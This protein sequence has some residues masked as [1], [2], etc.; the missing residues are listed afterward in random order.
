MNQTNT[1]QG[2]H[3][4]VAWPPL[5][6]ILIGGVLGLFLRYHEVS[7]DHGPEFEKIPYEFASY[8][9]VEERFDESA[10]QILKADTST[11]RRYQDEE[12]VVYWLFVAYFSSQKY[13]SQIHSPRHCLPGSGWRIENI[14][15]VALRLSDDT[16]AAT[17]E[18]SRLVIERDNRRRL[19][20]YWFET[21]SGVISGEYSLKLDLVKNALL[22]RPTD[23]AFVRLTVDTPDGDIKKAD[24][25]GKKFLQNLSES[26]E[27]ALPFSGK[28]SEPLSRK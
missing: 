9:G 27:S 1:R 3:T 15:P 20:L 17:I 19:M 26:L 23:A 16:S 2:G 6:M 12:G 8:Q 4:T 22:F 24:A 5:L 21:R 18:M 14:S 25:L 11:L 13:G 28:F 7:A 10:Y